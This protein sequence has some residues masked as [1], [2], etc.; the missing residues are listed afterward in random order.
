[1]SWAEDRVSRP[2]T[3]AGSTA[4]WVSSVE[5]PDTLTS[6]GY[7][8]EQEHMAWLIRNPDLIQLPSKDNPHPENDKDPAKARCVPRCHGR[9]ALADAV[10]AL[11]AN[12]AMARK[13]RIVFRPEWFEVESDATPD[14]D[15]AKQA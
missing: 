6:R 14:T 11:V 7:R 4:R 9:V 15:L 3:E 10:I 1:V 8:E 13:E 12:M 5:T 2:V